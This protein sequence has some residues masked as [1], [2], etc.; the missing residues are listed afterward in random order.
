MVKL[1]SYRSVMVVSVVLAAAALAGC[2]SHEVWTVTQ[3]AHP[4]PLVGQTHFAVAPLDFSDL[5]VG[6]ERE[7]EYVARKGAGFHRKW[8]D[9]KQAMN[10]LFVQQLTSRASYRAIRISE[11]ASDAPFVIRPRVTY[12]QRGYFGGAAQ[13]RAR[14]KAVVNITRDNGDL[15]DQI[16]VTEIVENVEDEHL[17]ITA[18]ARKRRLAEKLGAH[19]AQYVQARVVGS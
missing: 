16:V 12:L 5:K 15:V 18:G 6:K 4:N 17:N 13:Q 10:A 9:D 3:Y 1:L 8:L 14:L 11:T 7:S 19:T 2:S